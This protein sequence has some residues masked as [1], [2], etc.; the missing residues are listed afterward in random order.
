M[1]KLIGA[2]TIESAMNEIIVFSIPHLELFFQIGFG[3]ESISVVEGFSIAVMAPFHGSVLGWFARIDEMVD[4]VVVSTKLVQYRHPRS[5][6]V[7]CNQE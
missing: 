5:D 1:E 7:L 6:C 2:L 4:D 3:K